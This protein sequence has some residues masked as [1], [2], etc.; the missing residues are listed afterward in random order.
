MP[1][2]STTGSAND[3]PAGSVLASGNNNGGTVVGVGN[4]DT[5]IGPI[6]NDLAIATLA[7]KFDDVTGSIVVANV[8]TGAATT[9][10]VGVSGAIAGTATD[11]TKIAFTPSATQW[12]MQGGNVTSTLGGVANSV[13]RGGARDHNGQLNDAATEVARTK[14]NDRKLGSKSDEEFDVLARP[15]DQIV[16]GRT[17]GTGAGN[18]NAFQNTTD[19]TVAVT[20][21]V[22]PT[23]AVPGELTYHFGGVGKPTTDEYKAKDSYEDATDTSS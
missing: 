23:R 9:D 12:V 19:T 17:K 20:T 11:G 5:N 10:R 6:K 3:F 1:V 18:S 7:D 14:I 21:E 16:P 2:R 15:S 8:G 13:L 22:A 4:I